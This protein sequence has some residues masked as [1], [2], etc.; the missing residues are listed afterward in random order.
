[1]KHPTAIALGLLLL[2]L[3]T[4]CLNADQYC[5]DGI[6]TAL[7]SFAFNGMEADDY[8]GNLCTNELGVLSMAAAIKSYCL[9]TEITPG[10]QIIGEYCTENDLE[11]PAWTDVLAEL[12]DGF[13]RSLQVVEFTDIDASK[14]WNAS[15]LLSES[16]YK[17]SYRTS[18]R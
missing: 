6:Q 16:L 10:W 12:T 11:L 18:V 5:G 3:P 8:W 7:G 17:A 13:L 1:M 2:G 15:V 9:S 14:T 4:Y